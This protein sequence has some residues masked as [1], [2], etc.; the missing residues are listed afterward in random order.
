MYSG[1]VSMESGEGAEKSLEQTLLR[2]YES[3]GYPLV[4]TKENVSEV[5]ARIEAAENFTRMRFNDQTKSG[6]DRWLPEMVEKV[7]EIKMV[8]VPANDFYLSP[9]GDKKDRLRMIAQAVKRVEDITKLPP[10]FFSWSGAGERLTSDGRHRVRILQKLGSPIVVG[11]D[12]PRKEMERYMTD[13]YQEV[14]KIE[15]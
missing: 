9:K 14:L 3:A 11:Y 12:L 6:L 4:I 5:A 13:R 7:G 10:P 2:G 1:L 15:V 8:A